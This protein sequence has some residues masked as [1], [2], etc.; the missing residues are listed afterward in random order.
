L[1]M[2]PVIGGPPCSVVYSNCGCR[3]SGTEPLALC[4]AVLDAP[5]VVV[6]TA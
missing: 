2:M 4:Q 3:E 6:G 1:V 5:V